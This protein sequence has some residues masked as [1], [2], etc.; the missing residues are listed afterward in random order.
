[1]ELTTE[2]KKYL[3]RS[4]LCWL[5]TSSQDAIPNVSPKEIFTH[6]KE[7]CIII[8]NI[9]SPQTVINIKN[10]NNVCV[11]FVDVLVQK[12]F[13]LKGK[14]VIIKK[15]EPEFD[16]IEPLLLEMTKGVFPFSSVLKITI[17]QSKEILAP[18]YLFYPN[19]T[20]E[21]QIERAKKAYNL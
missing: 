8:A 17:D 7:D 21:E 18:R 10:N 20:E 12:G 11:S 19:T 16:E 14:A 13:Q 6:Y 2:I 3:D 15:N 9:A 1:M 5:A 4:V